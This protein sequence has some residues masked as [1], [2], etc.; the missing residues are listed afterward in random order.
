MIYTATVQLKKERVTFNVEGANF[1]NGTLRAEIVRFNNFRKHR[2]VK[3]AIEKPKDR[4]EF[5]LYD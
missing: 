5:T 4:A 2:L 3:V 1:L